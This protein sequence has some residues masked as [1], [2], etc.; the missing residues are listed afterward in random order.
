MT[1]LKKLRDRIKSIKST[2]KITSAMKMVATS[3]LRRAH[4]ELE[5]FHFYAQDIAK[6][7]NVLK[8]SDI[9]F[10]QWFPE[11]LKFLRGG[12]GPPLYILVSTNRG[13]CGA[14]NANLIR[15]LKSH[16]ENVS[17][18][19]LTG[20]GRKGLELLPSE[21]KERIIPLEYAESLKY[22]QSVKWADQIQNWLNENH[23]GSV[24]IMHYVYKNVL[25]QQLH[26]TSLVPSIVMENQKDRSF[27][28]LSCL[29][30]PS[31]TGVFSQLLRESFKI[32]LH[33]I[34]LESAACEH[35]ARMMAMDGATRNA[36]DMVQKLQ[37]RYN[38]T[39]QAQITSQLIEVISAAQAV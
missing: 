6:L 32:N 17:Q 18:F 33:N 28:N 16:L 36:N 11:D 10:D 12:E 22:S 20:I 8:N 38:Q 2:Q 3:K 31:Y 23:I 21:W 37:A 1:T 4:E 14:Y 24:H 5:K 15:F 30:E 34:L 39:R 35:A 27:H 13:L 7:L 29:T 19:F 9:G 25:H 26:K